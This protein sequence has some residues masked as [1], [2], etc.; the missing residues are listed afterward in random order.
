MRSI[1]ERQKPIRLEYRGRFI[2]DLRVD[3]V[4]NGLVVVEAQSH[5]TRHS[6]LLSCLPFPAESR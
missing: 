6:G 2:G 4:V 5:Q 3:L 1:L